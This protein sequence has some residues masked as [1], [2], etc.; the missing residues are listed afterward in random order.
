[1]HSC[2]RHHI[3]DIYNIFTIYTIIDLR[4]L[5]IASSNSQ[6]TIG[7]CKRGRVL[8]AFLVSTDLPCSLVTKQVL[9]PSAGKI[10]VLHAVQKSFKSF[11]N[12]FW[13]SVYLFYLENFFI[14][15]KNVQHQSCLWPLLPNWRKRSCVSVDATL[16][17]IDAGCSD[18]LKRH[19]VCSCFD[20][21]VPGPSSL[22]K[23]QS[24]HCAGP[25]SVLKKYKRELFSVK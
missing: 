7:S 8:F 12:C 22:C 13:V 24:V 9:G 21:T 6:P 16:P 4:Y 17:C 3:Y 15:S 19:N 18:S 2:H 23:H 20:A 14:S 11:Y 25:I 5:I 10:G 1:M